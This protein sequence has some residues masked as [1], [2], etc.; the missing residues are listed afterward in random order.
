MEHWENPCADGSLQN[1]RK[2]WDWDELRKVWR[3]NW[4]VLPRRTSQFPNVSQGSLGKMIF[5]L[6]RTNPNIWARTNPNIWRDLLSQGVTVWHNTS[7]ALIVKANYSQKA[8][9]LESDII[10]ILKAKGEGMFCHF[11]FFPNASST[12]A[13]FQHHHGAH[14]DE[15]L[16]TIIV[17]LTISRWWWCWSDYNE[18]LTVHWP[19][20]LRKWSKPFLQSI[21]F[22]KLH[23]HSHL[24]QAGWPNK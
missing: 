19:L 1:L 13:L 14:E 4:S 21:S 10:I 11:F 5:G 2:I 23:L 7:V 15:I 18:R 22:P 20:S 9:W 6:A 24:L 16:V 8:L 12:T 3:R 17:T